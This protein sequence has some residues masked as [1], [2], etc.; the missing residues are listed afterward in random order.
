MKTLNPAVEKE[1][2]K[3]ALVTANRELKNAKAEIKDSAQYNAAII[4][5]LPANIAL[6]DENGIIVAVNKAWIEF[7]EKN[8]MHNTTDGIGD[9]YLAICEKATGSDKQTALKMANALRQILNGTLRQ[10]SLE[11]PCHS[12]DQ[13]RW[14]CVEVRP[15]DE[16]KPIGAVVMHINITER[17]LAEENFK[18]SEHHFRSLIEN[19]TDGIVLINGDSETIYQSPSA[20]R[21]TGFT[22][23]E[24]KDRLVFEFI[25]PD[26]QAS[27][28]EFFQEVAANPGV[29]KQNQYRILHKLGHYIWIE[30]TITNLLHDESIKALV[31]N[32]REVTERKRAEKESKESE[33]RL[34]EAQAV[35]KVGSW[36]T[37]L[38]SLKVIWSAET[39]RI[40]ELDPNDFRN[41]HPDFLAFVHPDDRAKV[42]AAFMASLSKQSLNAIEH[43]IVTSSGEVKFVEE[44]WR[45]SYNEQKQPVSAVGT[46]QD[47]TERK[48]A[49]I[50]IHELNENLE[51]KVNERTAELT[52]ANTA[53][54]AFSYS[55]SHDLRAPVRSIM[56]FTKIINNEYAAGINEDVKELFTHIQDSAKRMNLIIDGLL[57]L[58]KAGK[59]KLKLEEVDLTTL[60]R[61]SWDS[62]CFTSPN[63][64]QLIL[65][66]MPVVYAD[67]ALL[68]QVVVNLLSNAVKYSSKKKEPQIGV[69]YEAT[70]DLVTISVED[71]G[72]GFDMRYYNKLFGAFQRLHGMSDFEGTGVGLMLVKRIVERHGGN[73]WAEAKEG[74]GA[75]FYFTLPVKQ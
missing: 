57:D 22:L 75:T 32:Y 59:E 48:L 5:T 15:I 63:K 7:A 11:Y 71:N 66:Q 39:Y 58:A 6:L 38:L 36:E 21:I 19:I 2:D 44:R 9:D 52:E 16:N 49:E 43:R 35:A 69:G 17:K 47:I 67:S 33:T 18:S 53:L 72:A 62:I 55:V 70:A 45:I 42:D 20:E 14:F 27:C 3:A 13:Q 25:H 26:D 74:E 40:F 12:P 37:D 31:V 61:G 23:Q 41:S 28:M 29:P 51:Q 8:H 50:V 73:V 4:N 56:G 64:A 34:N 24:T 30:G 46:C 65:P 54:E 10:F 1:N 60:F 68:Q